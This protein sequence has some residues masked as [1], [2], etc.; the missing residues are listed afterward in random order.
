MTAVKS[1]NLDW[2]NSLRLIALFAVIM[3]HVSAIPLG[4]YGHI[5]I[6]EWLVADFYNALVRFAVPV[7]VMITGAL[8]LHREYELSAFLKK[9]LSRVVVPFLFW[10]LVYVW[11]AWYNEELVFNGDAWANVK[12][13]LHQLKYGSSYHLWYVYMLIGLYFFIPIISKFVR[14]A[15]RR[16]VEYFLVMWL[17]VMILSQPV[18]SA[19]NTRVDLH[20]FAGYAGYLVLG[21]YLTFYVNY[22]KRFMVWMCVLFFTMLIVITIGT[23]LLYK[24]TRFITLLYE[25][26]GPTI[27]LLSSCVFLLGR[28]TKVQLPAFIV[29][30]KNFACEYN[31]GIYL[32]HAL[33]LYFLDEPFGISF[34]LCT[35]LISIPVTAIICFMLS[36]L[37]VW[38]LSKIPFAGKWLAGL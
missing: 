13:V 3:L 6:N 32:S 23:Y 9:R 1:Q 27:V 37:L 11:Y 7:F 36:L 38:L 35:P 18:I 4:Q 15:T 12:Q 20:Y 24:Y 30:A 28:F 31:F 17:A 25:P 21:H 14:N 5:P 19:I 33:I 16:E 29:K 22:S 8:T 2:I 26:V 34:K 10:S